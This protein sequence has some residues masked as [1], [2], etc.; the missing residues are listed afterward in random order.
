MAVII[1]PRL[2]RLGVIQPVVGFFPVR[3]VRRFLRTD[4]LVNRCCF[5]DPRA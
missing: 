2:Q 4:A 3:Q 1:Q 5:L